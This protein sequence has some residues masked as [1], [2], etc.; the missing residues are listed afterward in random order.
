MITFA[1]YMQN[2]ISVLFIIFLLSFSQ[3]AV[4][5]QTLKTFDPSKNI[6]AK[7]KKSKQKLATEYYASGDFEKASTLFEEL[8]KENNSSYF[9]KYLL[10]CYIQLEEYKKAEKMIKKAGRNNKKAYK[11]FSDLGYIQLKKGNI[12]KAN[13]MFKE[14]IESL[15]KNKAAVVELA[16]DFRSRG[17]TDLAEETYMVGKKLL[18]GDYSFEN[19][20]AYLYYYLEQYNRMTDEYLNLLEKQADQ[21]RIIQYRIQNAFRRSPE[22]EIYPYLKKETLKR[23]KKNPEK[24]QLSELLLWLS[25]QRKDFEIALIQAKSLDRRGGNDAYRVFD[26]SKVMLSHG[27]YNLSIQAL[28][29]LMK[30]PEADEQLYYSEAL[31]ELL[32]AKYL[33][34]QQVSIPSD[35]EI[36]ELQKD[37][38]TTFEELGRNRYTIFTVMKYAEFLSYYRDQSDEAIVELEDLISNTGINRNEKAPAKLLLGDLYLLDGNPWDAT[39]LFSQVEKDFKNDEIGFEARLRNA[40]LSFYIGEF[41]W[42]KAQLDILKAATGKK[43][44]N[45]AMKLSLFISENLDAD[46]STRALE[47][48]GRAELLHLRKKDSLAIQT[49]DSIFMLS[50]YHEVFDDVWMREAEIFMAA[51]QYDKSRLLLEKIV[52]QYPDGLLSDNAI[53]MLA[54]MELNKFDNQVKASEWYKMIL[55]EYPA[56][57]YSQQARDQF[58]ELRGDDLNQDE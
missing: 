38:D 54:E 13:S 20:L 34:F 47:L 53:W 22:N 55:T 43:I 58:R 10:Y 31:Q 5:S 17:Q 40:K 33:K 41:D 39:L 1:S 19:E 44:A 4:Q 7:P 16:N 3:Q 48:Y 26:L 52:A 56:S 29:Y 46:S 35:K 18:V 2:L 49:F 36:L 9:Y 30:L 11:K 24:T 42:A 51:H 15:P 27:E 45:D 32:S 25:I 8:Y 21:L 6:N 12:E 23:I 37:F 57:L 14:A 28:E 50:L